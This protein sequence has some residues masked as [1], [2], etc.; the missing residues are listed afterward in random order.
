MNSKRTSQNLE[1]VA[2]IAAGRRLGVLP[3]IAE[4]LRGRPFV[5]DGGRL[6]VFWPE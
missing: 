6:W 2:L 4:I 5:V 3:L 1:T